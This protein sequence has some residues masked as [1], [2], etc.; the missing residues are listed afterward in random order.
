MITKTQRFSESVKIRLI[1]RRMTV[2]TLA[3]RIGANRSN[4]STVIH[5]R[6][7]RMPR[8]ETAIRKELDL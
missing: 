2:T 7:Y 4:V 1:Q 8:I 6:R 3:K 5:G